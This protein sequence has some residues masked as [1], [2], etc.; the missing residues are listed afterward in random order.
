[1]TKVTNLLKGLADAG[2]D[3]RGTAGYNTRTLT[4]IEPLQ[5]KMVKG[6]CEP[7][8]AG[9]NKRSKTK[10]VSSEEPRNTAQEDVIAGEAC[11]HGVC[12][13]EDRLCH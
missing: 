11:H 2:S 6:I 1:M 9:L 10:D 4:T 8:E 13:R 7:S 12:S 3:K 5:N